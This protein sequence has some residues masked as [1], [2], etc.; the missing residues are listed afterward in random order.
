MRRNLFYV[1]N[2]SQVRGGLRGT[3]SE[4]VKKGLVG[5]PVLNSSKPGGRAHLIYRKVRVHMRKRNIGKTM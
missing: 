1:D 5:V 3:L 4:E 2:T